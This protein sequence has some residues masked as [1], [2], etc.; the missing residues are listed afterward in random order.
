MLSKKLKHFVTWEIQY[1]KLR[2]FSFNSYVYYKSHGFIAST[3]AFNLLL[4]L[5]IS[6][7]VLLISHLA[8]LVMQLVFSLVT[9]GFELITH[10]F[11]LITHGFEFLTRGFE[12]KT[13]GF[14]L[15]TWNSCFT[16][17]QNIWSISEMKYNDIQKKQVKNILD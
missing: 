1:F 14:E 8:L 3:H 17:P 15:V 2:I 10:D 11:A 9:H 12:L 5:L 4:E 16:F 13:C 6:K 7:L